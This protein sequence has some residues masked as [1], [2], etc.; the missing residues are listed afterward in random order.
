MRT[1][2]IVAKQVFWYVTPSQPQT[3]LSVS[4]QLVGRALQIPTPPSQIPVAQISV[5]AQ[6]AFERQAESIE[7]LS[8]QPR[9]NASKLKRA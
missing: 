7:L 1:P 3:G 4:G 6:S 9:V 8:P 5:S 2:A